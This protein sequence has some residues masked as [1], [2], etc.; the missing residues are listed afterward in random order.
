MHDSV[1]TFLKTNIDE[2][3]I[4]GLRVLEVGAQD[5]NGSPRTVIA[6]LK[7]ASYVGVDFQQGRGV[8]KV[9]DASRLVETF[10]AVAF[11]VV[12][13]TEML[14]HVK[15][16]KAAVSS[17]KRVLTF[18]GLLVVTTRGP[19]F[20]YHGYPHDYWRFTAGHFTDIFGDLFFELFQPD[21]Q[22]PGVFLKARK[23][24]FFRELDLTH[25]QVAQA[26]SP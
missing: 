5:V 21:P 25:I 16:W 20:P 2:R 8:D 13:S 10:G 22:F 15:D 24:E 18:G 26:P 23:P 14:E 3:E 12:I 17:M 11:D 6:P 4:K 19:G 7:P 1:M 9:V